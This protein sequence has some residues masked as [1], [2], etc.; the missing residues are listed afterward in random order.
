MFK[1]EQIG[2]VGPHT[3]ANDFSL[4]ALA[5]KTPYSPPTPRSA[6]PP[7]VVYDTLY[8]RLQTI[9]TTVAPLVVVVLPMLLVPMLTLASESWQAVSKL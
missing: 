5:G 9:S 1:K 3:R 8:Y 2:R 4:P 7:I 6:S